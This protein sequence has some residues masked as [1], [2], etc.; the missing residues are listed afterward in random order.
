MAFFLFLG[1]FIYVGIYTLWLKSRTVLNIIIGGA[2]GSAAVLSGS[3]AIGVWN[4]PGALVMAS[5]LFSWTP[6][7]F[8]SLAI[9][10]RDDYMMSDTPM[11]PVNLSIRQSAYWIMLHTIITGLAAISLG[12]LPELGWLYFGPVFATTLML[13]VQNVRLILYP[14]VIEARKM[15]HGSNI[16]L[17]II[18]LLICADI[19][20]V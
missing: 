10:C 1:A 17:A 5:L 9:V 18:I 6:M 4:D 15:F 13:I 20:F 2:A 12:V 7:H 19:A 11:L 16:Y 14:S 8:W 3:A